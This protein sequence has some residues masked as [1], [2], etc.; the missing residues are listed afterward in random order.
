MN[1]EIVGLGDYRIRWDGSHNWLVEKR[2][3]R[4][5]RNGGGEYEDFNVVGY[6]GDRLQDAARRLYRE[7][8]TGQSQQSMK[9]MADIM[10]RTEEKL[11]RAIVSAVGGA[12]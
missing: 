12:A 3:V 2:V 1:T 4:K 7:E 6:Y 10:L 8:L 9:T 5:K 11:E